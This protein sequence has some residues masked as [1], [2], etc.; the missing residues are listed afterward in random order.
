MKQR[1]FTLLLI[2]A[3]GLASCK[4]DKVEPDI[5]QYDNNQ[6]LSYIS[7]QGITGMQRDTT[8]GDTSGVYY[9]LILKGKTV[10]ANGKP[11][12][13][14]DYPD[15]VAFVFTL[16]SFDGKYSSVDTIANHFDDYLGH[17]SADALPLGLQLAI[18]NVLKY[19]GSSMRLL[20]PSH[21]AYGLKGSGT[22]STTTTNTHIAGN[23]CLD[24][25]VHVIDDFAT[26][27]DQVIKNNFDITGYT[28]VQSIA[29]PGNYYYYKTLTAGT[30][31]SP[32]T[33][34]STITTTYTGQLLNST[35]FDGSNNGDVIATL[36]IDGLVNGVT[37]GLENFA[38]AGTKISLIIPS[39]LGYA[40]NSQSS[41]PINSC[42]RFTFQV[43][44]VSP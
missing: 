44:T 35:I 20:I 22:G 1:I 37:E 11:I 18:K 8:G 24:Y 7:S 30:G 33:I 3:I 31:N 39:K 9:K 36:P 15:K 28:R 6:I 27:D 41:I 5:K 4:R 10:D 42:L 34:N 23:Q 25:Y 38:V 16:K 2:S 19:P 40:D 21:L 12:T 26:Y 32:I 17:I 43:I 14:L 29:N 13:P